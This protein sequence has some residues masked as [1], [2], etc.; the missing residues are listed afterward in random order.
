MTQNHHTVEGREIVDRSDDELCDNCTKNSNSLQ[1]D[2]SLLLPAVSAA[3]I[4]P[5]GYTRVYFDEHIG[6]MIEV[7]GKER[8][9]DRCSQWNHTVG[10]A[11]EVA[12]GAWQG[13][14]IDR[15]IL[16]DYEGDDGFDLLVPDRYRDRPQRIEVKATQDR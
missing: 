15:R 6:D 3:D 13:V 16:P 9:P 7:L 1:M 11:G 12:V 2:P 4:G 10:V 5:T 14:P 8:A